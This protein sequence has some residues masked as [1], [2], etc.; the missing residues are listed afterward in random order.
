M[1]TAARTV[2]HETYSA[3]SAAAAFARALEAA[4]DHFHRGRAQA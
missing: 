4:R 1:G 2:V 3:T